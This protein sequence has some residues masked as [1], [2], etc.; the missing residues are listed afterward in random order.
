MAIYRE[1]SKELLK[2]SEVPNYQKLWWIL[3]K[4]ENVEKVQNNLA[5]ILKK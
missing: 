4:S 5:E 3:E 1:I 2:N